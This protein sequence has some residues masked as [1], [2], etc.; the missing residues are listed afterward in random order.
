M[1][2]IFAM[3]N[4]EHN[5]YGFQNIDGY[6]YYPSFVCPK[7][8]IDQARAKEWDEND[9]FCS[10]Y[11]K[12]GTHFAMLTTLL[13]GFKG[14]LPPKTDLH[15]LCYSAEF[16]VG[17]EG[18][19]A[20]D[21]MESPDLYPTKPR[22]ISSHMP[23]H[24]IKFNDVTRFMYVVR[25]PVNSMASWR[26]MNY[27]MFGPI[28]CPTI[29][30]FIKYELHSRPYGWLDHVL[31]WWSMRE[32][33]N[34]L[35]LSYEEMVKTPVD[36]VKKIAAH[37]R[38]PL[39]EAQVQ[40]VVMCMD[41]KWAL[42]NIDPYLY[43]IKTPFSPP[44]RENQSKSAFIVDETKVTEKLTPAQELEIRQ[45]Y[46]RKIQKIMTGADAVAAANAS[47]FFEAHREYFC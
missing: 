29:A 1:Y 41:K 3:A 28:M 38:V 15:C 19:N 40:K 13:I 4:G 10:T 42:E 31:G 12:C 11:P 34:V 7:A 9:L 24:H 23:H 46:T 22:V 47:S 17:P 44:E 45:E 39:T 21:L 5:Y 6:M 43:Q 37:M 14:D 20:R 2:P 25:D 18:T 36:A 35:I 27:L 32:K 30:D 33:R 26:R 16:T 8:L